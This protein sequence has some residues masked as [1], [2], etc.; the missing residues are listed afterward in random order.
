MHKHRFGPFAPVAA[1]AL[2]LAL[3]V[4]AAAQPRGY[5]STEALAEQLDMRRTAMQPSGQER[6]NIVVLRKEGHSV[7]VVAGVSY[8]MV[9]QEARA[10]ARP[11][12]EGDDD[13]LVPAEFAAELARLMDVPYEARHAPPSPV[14][15]LVMVDPGHG[16]KDPG[17]VGRRLNLLEKDV[18]LDVSQRVARMLRERGV[19]VRMTRTTDVFIELDDRV[20]MANRARPDL[21]VSI[22]ADA[23]ERSSVHGS[24]VFYPDDR[25]GGGVA[26]V[27][28]RA[29]RQSRGG[30]VP[31]DEIGAEGTLSRPV[32]NA[33]LGEMMQE[34]RSR[35]WRA[36][37]HILDALAREAGTHSRGVREAPFRVVRFPRCPSVLVELDFLTN[38]A[39]EQRMS[40]PEHRERLARGVAEG[41]MAY[42]D[43]L[44]SEP[45][46][47][48][49]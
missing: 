11:V 20:A 12:I 29:K 47:A 18:A 35:S 45:G 44:G 22:H 13:L 9:N 8:V 37:R 4:G 26:D 38:P 43:E 30:A 33:V 27:E 25:P 31:L 28:H 34:Y 48:S 10:L 32:Q 6:P 7:T 40:R 23:A 19:E 5:E 17:A 49:R 21:F 15:R 1:L 46:G 2:A 36:G 16:G 14:R 24:T 39:A 41:V 42:L 3:A